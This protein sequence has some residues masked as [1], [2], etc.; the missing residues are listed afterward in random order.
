M[1]SEIASAMETISSAPLAWAM[2]GDG[3]NI[4]NRPEEVGRLD[5]HAGGLGGDCRI[6]RG[7][8]DAAVGRVANF[9]DGNLLVLRVGRDDLAI[10]GMHRAG[11][12]G[13]VA[14]GDAHGHHH[15]FGRAG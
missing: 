7:Q 2:L 3:R 14:A 13:A 15:R 5:Q 6:Q 10:L 11:D 8:I 9:A 4:L 1:P 12:D